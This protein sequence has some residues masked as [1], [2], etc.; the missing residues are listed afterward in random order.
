ML[1][2]KKPE[3]HFPIKITLDQPKLLSE[4]ASS[5]TDRLKLDEP[6]QRIVEFTVA[7]LT[8]IKAKTETAIQRASTGY[9]RRP[10]RLVLKAT[11]NAIA[12]S[13]NLPAADTIY[14]FKIT[15]QESHPPI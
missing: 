14:Q 13:H 15:L 11:D 9:E 4:F 5:F 3:L 8:A 6:N 10:L 2:T 1:R 7:E 12:Q